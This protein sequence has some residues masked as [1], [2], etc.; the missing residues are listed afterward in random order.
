MSAKREVESG[1]IA[2]RFAGFKVRETSPRYSSVTALLNGSAFL[3]IF[4]DFH[5]VLNSDVNSKD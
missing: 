2:S 3:A 5:S 4:P 1:V